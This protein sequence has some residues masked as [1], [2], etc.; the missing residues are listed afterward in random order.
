[1][2]ALRGITIGRKMVAVALTAVL[3]LA[4]V[5]A[6]T[7]YRDREVRYADRMNATR[8]VVQ[9][10][11]GVVAR[12]GQL[13]QDGTLSRDE[14]QA[15]ALGVLKSLRYAGS[16][17]FWVNSLD[18]HMIMHPI[19]PALDGTDVSGLKDGDGTAIF[20]RFGQIVSRSGSGYL[21]Y[22][23]P[24]PGSDHP[25]PK[26]S[27]VQGYAPWGW[28][29]G[30]GVYVDDVET[31]VQHDVL[32]LVGAIGVATLL[33]CGLV[34]AVRRSITRPIADLTRLLE[35]GGFG[36][37]LSH[38]DDRTELGRLAGAV[39]ASLGRIA[40]V[41]DRVGKVAQAVTQHVGELTTSSR[42]IE[43]QAAWTAEHAGEV[44]VSSS[45]VVGGYREIARS[46][47]DIDGS[48]RT[49]AGSVQEVSGM[50]SRAVVATETTNEVVGR[51][52]ASSVEIDAVVQ[53]ITAIAEQTNL[54]ALNATIESARAGD[55]GKGFAVVA[56][57]V[58]ELAQETARATDD[59][60]RRIRALQADAH[61]SVA[62]ISAIGEIITQINAHQEGIAAAV[63]EQTATMA[64]VNRNVAESTRAG[65][66]SG[67]ALSAVAGAA[68]LTRYQLDEMSGTMQALARL[69]HDLEEAVA[70]FG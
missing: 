2:P 20:V 9:T 24:K 65:E 56:T 3:C 29:V 52:E 69:S 67:A 34:L 33:L 40:E 13:Q 59:I 45:A 63:E 62:A 17:Y 28:V 42:E 60:A 27:Y 61:E 36:R 30:S 39:D 4:A 22:L 8:A 23:W 58:K 18:A 70:V 6:F 44:S 12:F 50:A 41:V 55:A 37:R 26:I 48:I 35:D 21:R 51:L 68:D 11:L 66:G 43:E 19:K 15:Q 25:Q 57:E 49:I 46:V 54:L 1:M 38:G 47:D 7:A 53:T 16:E 31:A 32:A 10:A 14:A 64:L 5:G